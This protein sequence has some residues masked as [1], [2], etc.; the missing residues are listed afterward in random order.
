ML[1]VDT[2]EG[3]VYVYGCEFGELH[4]V[5][6]LLVVEYGVLMWGKTPPVKLDKSPPGASYAK[7]RQHAIYLV[8]LSD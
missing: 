8:L 1:S 4:T 5:F 2:N 7:Y 3:I 6:F